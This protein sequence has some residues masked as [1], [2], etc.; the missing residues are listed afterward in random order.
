MIALLYRTPAVA[1]SLA[2]LAT[3]S[4]HS[5]VAEGRILF[6]S[7]FDRF[8]RSLYPVGYFVVREVVDRILAADMEHIET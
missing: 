5:V 4:S 3:E 1:A 2:W 6:H 8:E 7:V